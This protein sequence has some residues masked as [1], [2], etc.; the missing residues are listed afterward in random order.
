VIRGF[1]SSSSSSAAGIQPAT[2]TAPKR[3]TDGRAR[4]REAVD[5]VGLVVDQLEG[6]GQL[7]AGQLG[8]RGSSYVRQISRPVESNSVISREPSGSRRASE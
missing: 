8:G 3:R 7:E 4:A 2:L 6:L 5:V 1:R